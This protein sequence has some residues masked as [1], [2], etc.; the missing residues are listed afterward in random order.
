[1]GGGGFH[2]NWDLGSQDI[3]LLLKTL[4][5]EVERTL[6]PPTQRRCQAGHKR[7]VVNHDVVVVGPL[8]EEEEGTSIASYFIFGVFCH[9]RDTA[10]SPI[11]QLQQE[12][13]T[14]GVQ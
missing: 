5:N 6:D 14:G 2:N 10:S 1:M 12:R 11:S 4:T 9:Y 8:K 7:L 3:F 13:H